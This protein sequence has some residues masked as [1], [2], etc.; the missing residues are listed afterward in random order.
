MIA[1]YNAT[2]LPEGPDRVPLLMKQT[3]VKRSTLRGFIVWDFSSQM[4]DF[5]N[6]MTACL[7]AGQVKYRE[8]ITNG[9][10]NAPHELIG[11]LRGKNFGKKIIRLSTDPYETSHTVCSPKIPSEQL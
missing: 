4:P 9:L 1:H 3:L 2:Q 8:D 11:L 10:E 5:L 6:D 7:K